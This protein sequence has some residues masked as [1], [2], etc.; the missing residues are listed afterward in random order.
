MR[1]VNRLFRPEYL[2]LRQTLGLPSL[3]PDALTN[4]G[5]ENA[6]ALNTEV[7]RA[8]LHLVQT[9]IPDCARALETGQLAFV[10][11]R[12]VPFRFV[13]VIAVL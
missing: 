3:S 1:R 10:P 9:V 5:R 2:R 13:R 4:W 7:M 6:V 11:G 8:T 12:Y